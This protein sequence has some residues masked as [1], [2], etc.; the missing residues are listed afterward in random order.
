MSD[1][2]ITPGRRRAAPLFLA[3][4]TILMSGLSAGLD[5]GARALS[6]GPHRPVENSRGAAGSPGADDPSPRQPPSRAPSVEGLAARELLEA[7]GL[8]GPAEEIP[9]ALPGTRLVEVQERIARFAKSHGIAIRQI[10]VPRRTSSGPPRNG[11]EILRNELADVDRFHLLYSAEGYLDAVI[12]AGDRPARD[13]SWHFFDLTPYYLDL[14]ARTGLTDAEWVESARQ[15]LRRRQIVSEYIQFSGLS[16]WIRPV[17]ILAKKPY[18]LATLDTATGAVALQQFEAAD[19]LDE[20]KRATLR[21]GCAKRTDEM[22][23]MFPVFPTVYSPAIDNNVAQARN[24]GGHV[25]R[26][27]KGLGVRDGDRVLDVGTGSGYLAWV[28]WATARALG[29]DVE[30][31]AIDINPLSVANAKAMARLAGYRLAARVYDNV[32]DLDDHYAFPGTRFRFVIWDMPTIPRLVKPYLNRPQETGGPRR[33]MTYWDDG[34]GALETL[35]RFASTL[36]ELLEPGEGGPRGEGGRRTSGAAVVW[37]TV[38]DDATDIVGESFR[39]EGLRTDLL[40]R[41]SAGRGTVTCVVYAVS[42]P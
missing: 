1:R 29:R 40:E 12:P 7:L 15:I 17:G 4:G 28:A 34:L 42:L 21:T 26:H 23:I 32:I 2:S 36:P 33:L 6:R 10:E 31:Y 38:P 25:H 37:N 19:V 9:T 16:A 14:S 20:A 39:S 5:E 3:F 35:R 13:A 24:F 41:Y 11:V 18:V 27:L 22:C 30:M 8:A